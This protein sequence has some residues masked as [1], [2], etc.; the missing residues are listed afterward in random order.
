MLNAYAIE[1]KSQIVVATALTNAFATR[2]I[3]LV[4]FAGAKISA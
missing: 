2:V 4:H 3:G 1:S